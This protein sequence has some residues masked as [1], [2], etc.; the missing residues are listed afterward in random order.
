MSDSRPRPVTT[1][2]D[3]LRKRIDHDTFD[4]AIFSLDAVAADLGYGDV[5][6]LGGS[7]AWIG[8][9]RD[10]GKKIA[11]VASGERARAALDLA[12]IE[13]RFD[14]VVSGQPPKQGIVSALEELGVTPDRALL[15][16]VD[17]SEL[18]AARAAGIRLLIGVA[19][20]NATP[21]QL[22]RASADAIVADLQELLR[23]I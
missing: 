4:A 16:G 8:R 10:E 23:P 12:G 3:L 19:R 20:G 21:E 7:I 2:L 6:A 11:V 9:L 22:R 17:P 14:V 1:V 13:D 15:A 18:E 5:R